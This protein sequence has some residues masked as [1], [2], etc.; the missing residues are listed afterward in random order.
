MKT[1]KKPP[2]VDWLKIYINNREMFM[3][4][5]MAKHM[6][7]YQLWLDKRYNNIPNKNGTV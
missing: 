4:F 7:E 5:L 3:T 6:N 2:K 1:E